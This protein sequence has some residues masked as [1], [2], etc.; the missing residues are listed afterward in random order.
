MEALR[1]QGWAAF[2]QFDEQSAVV[3]R[4][5]TDSW[6]AESSFAIGSASTVKVNVTMRRQEPL[7]LEKTPS[8][9]EDATDELIVPEIPINDEP[10]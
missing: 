7:G 6:S 4:L 2:E 5:E 10:A 1:E 8:F 9:L 3:P